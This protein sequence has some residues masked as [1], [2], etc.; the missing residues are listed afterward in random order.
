MALQFITSEK[1]KQKLLV[2]GHLFFKEKQAAKTYWKCEMYQ[3]HRCR[4]RVT[5]V[6]DDIEVVKGVHNHIGDAAHVEA[7]KMH[8]VV[9]DR[10]INSQEAPQYIISDASV[11]LTQAVAGH[12]AKTDSI[13]RTIRNIRIRKHAA[14]ALPMTRQEFVFPKEY[15]MTK[16]G[17][18]FLL[19]DSGPT[20]DR[21]I[22]FSTER[23]L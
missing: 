4:V 8:D 11:G 20:E 19:F 14:P 23:N 3:K 1:G 6:G 15:K 7:S 13:K 10:A 9:R 18:P 17:E 2:D 22:I 16:E 21:I 12:I 5:K